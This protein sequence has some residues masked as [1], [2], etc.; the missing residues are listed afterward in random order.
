[1]GLSGKRGNPFSGT[2]WKN[3]KFYLRENVF[4]HME[5]SQSPDTIPAQPS[6]LADPLLYDSIKAS[7]PIE[8]D[9]MLAC[10]CIHLGI[11]QDLYIFTNSAGKKINIA[12]VNMSKFNWMNHLCVNGYVEIE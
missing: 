5:P 4:D 9:R 8:R 12:A 2:A 3:D 10:A 6:K 11:P 7:L 1:M